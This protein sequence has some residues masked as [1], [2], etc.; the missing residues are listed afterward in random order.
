MTLT[1]VGIS[2]QRQSPFF[3]QEAG[4]H[5]LGDTWAQ[6]VGECQFIVCNV[7]FEAIVADVIGEEVDECSQQQVVGG[8]DAIGL[9]SH[10]LLDKSKGAF[11]LVHGVGTFQNFVEDDEKLLT[12]LQLVYDE[13]Q[14]FEFGKEVGL[15]VVQ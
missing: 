11:L 4:V 15:V 5:I 13:F 6:A 8:N 10:E 12:S 9:Q 14:T 1:V 3:H 7:C 2:R